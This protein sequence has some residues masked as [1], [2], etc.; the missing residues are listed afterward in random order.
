ME[1]R[2]HNF[3]RFPRPRT[4][5][6]LPSAQLLGPPSL[7]PGVF[8]DAELSSARERRNKTNSVLRMPKAVSFADMD[9]EEFVSEADARTLRYRRF[10]NQMKKKK[11]FEGVMR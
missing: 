10:Q 5:G 1:E 3:E 7:F 9:H 2:A 11:Q 8:Q 4:P 6:T